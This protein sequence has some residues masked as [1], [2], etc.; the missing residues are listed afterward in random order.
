MD[1]SLTSR[2]HQCTE[3]K[4]NENKPVDDPSRRCHAKAAV[5]LITQDVVNRL[6]SKGRVVLM[7]LL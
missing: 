4:R 6:P 5:V 7:D 2:G 1:T 3:P